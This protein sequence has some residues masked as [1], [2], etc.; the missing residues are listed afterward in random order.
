M[1]MEIKEISS[2]NNKIIKHIK[3]LELKK[4]RNKHKQFLIE[5]LRIVEECIKYNGDIEYIIYSEKI[6][7]AQGGADLLDKI[8]EKG[9]YTYKVPNN[10]FNKISNTETPQGIM[11]VVNMKETKLQEFNPNND[12][13]L[14]FVILD[15]IQDPGNMGT[16]IRTSES[17]NVDA[18]IVTKG[19]V[20]LYNN[21]TLRATMGSIFHMPIIQC[22]NDEWVEYLKKKN[23]KLIAADLDTDKTYI[24]IDYKENIGIIVGNEANGIKEDILNNVDEKVIIPILGKIESLNASVAAGILIYKAAEEKFLK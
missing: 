22:D 1:K 17:A 16:I 19:S 11:A 24:D 2:E 21:K 15:R 6:Y 10:L 14:F 3:S 4:Q 18:V 9:Y 12:K 8:S 5:G 23:V 7:S 13:N 20:D